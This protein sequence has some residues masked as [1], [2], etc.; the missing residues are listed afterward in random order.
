MAPARSFGR[1]P[2]L[3]AAL[4]SVLLAATKA[5]AA[6]RRYAPIFRIERS[7]NANVVQY[8][9][10]ETGQARLD[11][12]EPVVAYWILYAKD[13]RREPLGAFEQRA[14]GFD[15][16]PESTSTWLMVLRAVPQRSIRVM[17]WR[18]RW[19]AQTVIDGKNAI[20]ERIF[21]TSDESGLVPVVRFLDIFGVD[22][23]SGAPV[24]ERLK[25]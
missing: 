10:V 5:G 8:D 12:S 3:H 2:L 16:K 14:Y 23:A 21:V 4:G 19:V 20:L 13:G 15:V 9:A 11:P 24:R 18:D 1:R 25:P 6:P 17:W 22:L 7:K